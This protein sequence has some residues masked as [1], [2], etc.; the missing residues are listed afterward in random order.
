M[1]QCNGSGED[2]DAEDV[3]FGVR[4][5]Y[6]ISDGLAN[7]G[8]LDCRLIEVDEPANMLVLLVLGRTFYELNAACLY[9]EI[10]LSR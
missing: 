3:A 6:M 5:E 1:R 4:E 8:Y 9:E 10:L 7:E 2:C